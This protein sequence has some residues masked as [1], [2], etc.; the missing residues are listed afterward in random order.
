[1]SGDLIPQDEFIIE[2][3][4]VLDN[5]GFDAFIRNPLADY[6]FIVENLYI[7]RCDKDN[8]FHCIY[9]TSDS[10]DF[11]IL[12]ES[13]GYAYARYAAYLPKKLIEVSK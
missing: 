1:M 13:E 8:V 11:G 9:A 5:L 2:K 7:M 10:S 12:I 4:I 6:G 3:T